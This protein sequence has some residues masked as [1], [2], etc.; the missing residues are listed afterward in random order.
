MSHLPTII[1]D[2][3]MIL[4]VAGVTTILFKK[5]NQPLV[6]GYIIA[7]FITGPNFVFFPTVADKVNVQAWSEIGVIFL[8]FALGLE[9]SFYKLKKV[10]STAFVSTA[11]IICSMLFVGY[12]VG[13]LLGWSHMDSIFLGGMLSM[14][15]TAIIIKAFDDLQLREKSFTEV[16][17]GVL[18]V[19][20]IAGIAMMVILATIAV[21]TSGISTVEL[22][23]SVGRLVFFLVLWFVAGMYLIPTFFKKAQKL[24][25]DETL[26]VVSIGLCLGMVYLATSLGFSSALGAF[27]MGSLIAEAPNAEHIEHLVSPIKDLFGAVF[28]VSVGM[29][30]NPALLADYAI[31][32]AVLVAT[33]ILGQLFFSTCGVLAA[34]QK[35]HT[36][37]LCGFSLTQ[38]GEFSFILATLGMNLGVTSDFLYPIIVAVSVITTF[39]TPFFINAAEPAYAKLVKILPQHFLDWLERYTDNNDI[40]GDQDWKNLLTDYVLHMVIYATLLFAIML[41][42]SLYLLPYLQDNLQLPYANFIAA[43]ATFLVMAPLLRAILVNRAGSAELFSILWFKR[44]ANHLPLMILILGKVLLASCSLYFIFNDLMGIH[45]ILAFGAIIVAVYFIASSDWLMGEYLR[46]ES[47]FLVNL[48]EK[49]MRKHREAQGGEQGHWFDEELYLAYYKVADN[50]PIIGKTMKQLAVRQY[51]G[52][53]VLQIRTPQ[54]TIDMPGGEVMVT[55]GANLL[56]I[57]S[58]SQL[59]IMDAAIIQRHLELHR[60]WGPVTMRQFMLEDHAYAPEQQFLSLAITI[61]KHSPILGTSLKAA[62]LRQK[63]SCLVIGLERGAF[64]ITNPN[65]SLVFE[66]NDLLWVLGKQK[67][68]NTLIR[69]EIL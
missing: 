54:A 27:I 61:D 2:L 50:S 68:M 13:Q 20:D 44:R 5:I 43:A 22:A 69:E 3:A 49:H 10:G 56:L 36:A 42:S 18:I 26:V 30:V 23:L 46:I 31:P 9:F 67:M 39:T 21:A 29:M 1:T 48:N 17:F 63:W 66:E 57:G 41:G 37:V 16:V 25:T 33:T 52:C 65:V 55:K 32:V 4:L 38:I 24:M 15:S 7:G 6:L 51:Y 58:A 12:G 45:G 62:D 53:N 8:L 59:K 47:R 64:T 28:F 11:V 34:G 19:E 40:K 60:L 14:S 35:L